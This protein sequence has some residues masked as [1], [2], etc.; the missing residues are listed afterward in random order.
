MIIILTTDQDKSKHNTKR[1]S[2]SLKQT[3]TQ[4]M[5]KYKKKMISK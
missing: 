4:H 1:V 5:N 3:T 2:S